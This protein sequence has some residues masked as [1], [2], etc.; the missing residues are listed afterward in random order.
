MLINAIIINR[1][2]LTT[3]KHTVDFLEKEERIN[4]IYIIDNDS[5]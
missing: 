5:T 3:L 4:N 1:N 2:L